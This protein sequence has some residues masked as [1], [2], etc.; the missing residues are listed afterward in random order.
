[1]DCG[2]LSSGVLIFYGF[3]QGVFLIYFL[4][5]ETGWERISLRFG[6]WFLLALFGLCG[7]NGIPVFLRML[8]ARIHSFLNYFIIRCTT[9][10]QSRVI[11]APLLSCL[12]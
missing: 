10:P 7:G 4:D 1:M 8:S 3:C 12:S 2:C 9:G 11:L 6:I 5:S